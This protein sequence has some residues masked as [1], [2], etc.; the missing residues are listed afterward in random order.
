M[1]YAPSTPTVDATSIWLP[2][3][4][5]YLFLAA[6]SITASIK[7]RSLPSSSLRLQINAWWYLFPLISVALYWHALGVF[8]LT[9]LI[10]ALAVRELANYYSGQ[11]W[12]FWLLCL[13]FSVGIFGL[14]YFETRWHAFLFPGLLLFLFALLYF[15]HSRNTLLL[16]L[17]FVTGYSLGFI[18]ELNRLPF[19]TDMVV[20]WMFYLFVIT[21]LNDVAQFIS[22]TRFG[23][24]KIAVSISPNKTWQGLVGGVIISVL[25]SIALGSYLLLTN[26]LTLVLLGLLLS[27][28]GFAGD[29]LFSAA[30]RFLAIK[31]FSQLIPGH[32]GILDRVDSLV[33]TAPLLYFFLYFTHNGLLE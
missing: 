7:T 3:V 25:I 13:F 12:H 19:S 20:A 6:A 10:C 18:N 23:K 29:M 1:Q 28:G 15:R 22:G 8:F 27:L 9:L 30:K 11:R 4:I 24:Q 17:F 2:T 33:A 16:G 5:L 32:G 21:A 26:T 31:D 14:H